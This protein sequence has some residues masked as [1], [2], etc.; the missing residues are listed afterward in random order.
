[1]LEEIEGRGSSPSSATP[2][3]AKIVPKSAGALAANPI[4]EVTDFASLQSYAAKLNPVVK[5]FDPLQLGQREFWPIDNVLSEESLFSLQAEEGITANDRTIS[6]LRHAEIKHGRV[7]MA[8]FVGWCIQANGIHFPWSL[9]L[10]GSNPAYAA[11]LSPPEQWDALP[12]GAKYQLLTVIGFLEF[13]GEGGGNS[14]ATDKTKTSPTPHYTKKDGL[15]G[16]FPSF[17]LFSE[18]VHPVPFNL[19]DPFGFAKNLSVEKAQRGLQAE[20]NNG[21]LAMIGIFGFVTESKISGAVPFI[22]DFVK[23]YAGEF[24][25]PLS[26]G[27]GAL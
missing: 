9:T 8:A 1:M 19:Y 3:S 17:D 7:A 24:M 13:W 21:R 4:N 11:G 18:T 23:P 26:H 2:T 16:Q 22:H 14:F 10:D 25:A 5:Y 20:V 15:P 12:E 27:I 6:W